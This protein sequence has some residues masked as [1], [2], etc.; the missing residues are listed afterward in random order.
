MTSNVIRLPRPQ[1]ARTGL[2]PLAFFVRAGWNDHKE[3]LELITS[4]E[5]GAFGFVIDA[6]NS[7]RHKE[8]I[9]ESRKRDFDVVLDPKTQHLALP[10]S[11]ND[12]LNALPWGG[13]GQHHL[14]FLHCVGA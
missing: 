7:E 2:E 3:L 9:V 8:L 1:S 4:G 13:T 11:Y 6:Q 10:G 5:R 12:A 14:L